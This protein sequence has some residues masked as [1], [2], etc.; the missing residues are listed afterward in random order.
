MQSLNIGITTMAVVMVIDEVVVNKMAK[1]IRKTL[2]AT[3]DDDW[4]F[5]FIELIKIKILTLRINLW[6][7]KTKINTGVLFYDLLTLLMCMCSVERNWYQLL[8]F[9]SDAVKWN[10]FFRR[11][12]LLTF[13]RNEE[14][15]LVIWQL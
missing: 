10:I 7:K 4:D 8:T 12:I 5:S 13:S 1:H 2:F 9:L 3:N 15:T 14:I 6:I 11:E